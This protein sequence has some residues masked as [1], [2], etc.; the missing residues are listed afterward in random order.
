MKYKY[1]FLIAICLLLISGLSSF[2]YM[3]EGQEK[4][5]E[6]LVKPSKQS[7]VLG[8]VVRLDFVIKNSGVKDI[9]IMGSLKIEDGYLNVYISK[10]GK[11]FGQY[12]HTKWGTDD[13]YRPP[14]KLK[15]GEGITNSATILWNMKPNINGLNETV[16]K[17]AVEGKILTDYAFPEAG[18]YF[19]KASYYI[20]ST[21]QQGAVLIESDLIKIVIEEPASEE[22]EVWNKI[23]NNG[24]I[25]HFIQEGDFSVPIYKTKERENLRQEIEQIINQYPNSFYTESLQQSLAKFRAAEEKRQEYLQKIQKQ[26]EKPQ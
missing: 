23:K 20:Y 6:L 2:S 25:A 9:T 16:A 14:V 10:D 7:Y 26:Q 12:N 11:N 18:T 24:D 19:V 15:P 3:Q 17:K 21:N 4:E 1:L 5:L 8:E 13:T 22:L